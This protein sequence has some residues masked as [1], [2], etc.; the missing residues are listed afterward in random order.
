MSMSDSG[1]SGS[2]SRSPLWFW[3]FLCGSKPVQKDHREYRD[4]AR[5]Q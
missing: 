4:V 5:Y 2:D 3:D 1:E